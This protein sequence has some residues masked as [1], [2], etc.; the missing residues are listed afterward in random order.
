MQNYLS[1][2]ALGECAFEFDLATMLQNNLLSGGQSPG[3]TNLALLV[4]KGA[5]PSSLRQQADH[6]CFARLGLFI[7]LIF[8]CH[9][10][11]L[12]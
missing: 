3:S 9:G 7:Y 12:A 5:Q 1:H 2:G 10:H 8:N 6:G 4:K 11:L